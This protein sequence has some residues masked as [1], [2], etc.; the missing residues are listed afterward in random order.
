MKREFIKRWLNLCQIVNLIDSF[1]KKWNSK[2][3]H[4]I[5]KVLKV[6]LI[7]EEK[8]KKLLLFVG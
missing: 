3:V 2:Y 6:F 8:G 1:K 4:F 7:K 5:E